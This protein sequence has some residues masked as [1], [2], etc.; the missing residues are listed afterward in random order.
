MAM[1]R[2]VSL[3]A[4]CSCGY[5]RSG[6]TSW[7]VTSNQCILGCGDAP[8]LLEAID[9]PFGHIALAVCCL[10]E[11][12]LAVQFCPSMYWGANPLCAVRRRDCRA[13]QHPCPLCQ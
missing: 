6:T 10:V 5:G 8:E 3:P 1:R 2:D 4:A 7:S 13:C 9:E 12:S 11:R